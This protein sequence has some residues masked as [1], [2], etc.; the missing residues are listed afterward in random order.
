MILGKKKMNRKGDLVNNVLGAII[1]VV[2]MA[3]L[4]FAVWKLYSVYANQEER[5]AQ[6]IANTIEARVNALKEGES[7]KF[8]VKGVSGW[9][10]SGWGLSESP[11]PDACF[12]KS[13][14]CVCEGSYAT[15]KG[16]MPSRCKTKGF[17]R[18]FD[19]E[20]VKV[21]GKDTTVVYPPAGG[22]VGPSAGITVVVDYAIS[23]DK[24]N[25]IELSAAKRKE[26]EKE[27]LTLTRS[28]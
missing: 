24:E 2:G 7:G 4:F 26:G 10:I 12:F 16:D 14:I 19:A 18:L 27:I 13:C 20:D 3:L 25:L 28:G 1:A 6:T 5:N 11:R 17:C 22:G 15:P 9:F 23:L 21:I 8:V